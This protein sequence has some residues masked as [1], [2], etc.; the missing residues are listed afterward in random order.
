MDEKQIAS[1]KKVLKK[2]SAMRVT[3]SD[4]ERAILDRLVT[5]AVSFDVEAHVLADKPSADV[6]QTVP[7][8]IPADVNAHVLADRPSADVLQT[9]PQTIPQDVNAHAFVN[10]VATKKV[11]IKI[12]FDEKNEVYKLLD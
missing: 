5:G 6:L 7:Q 10:K 3:L 1:T 11:N 4:D 2:L 12:I 9:I 8:T